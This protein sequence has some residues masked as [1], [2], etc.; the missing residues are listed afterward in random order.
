[1]SGAGGSN[2]VGV[3]GG[4]TVD[5]G[6]YAEIYQRHRR[7]QPVV[8]AEL[9]RCGQVSPG[10]LVLEVGCGTANYLTAILAETGADGIGVDP[11]EAMQAQVMAHTG[12]GTRSLRAGTAEALPVDSAT[13]DFAFM[14]DV[15]HVVQEL[16]ATAQELHRVLKPGGRLAI[17]TDS[18]EDIR[19][20]VPLRSHF[21]ETVAVELRRY[22]ALDSLQQ[23]LTTAGF[24]A[25]ALVP[26]RWEYELTDIGMYRERAA[27]SL[28]L[29]DDAAH[30]RGMAR[31]EADLAKGPIKAVSRY[32]IVECVRP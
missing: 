1:M 26:A 8:L 3:C 29:I 28:R 11:A 4:M 14:V 20:R 18:E 16:A 31:L 32:T 27:S 6:S 17:A 10:Q 15:I 19:N 22:P 25:I 21:P 9:L 30:A 2:C 13:V 5:F 12:S 7:T 24:S 23:H